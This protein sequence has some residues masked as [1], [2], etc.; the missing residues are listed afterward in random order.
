MILSAPYDATDPFLLHV[1]HEYLLFTT[2]GGYP[3]DPNVPVN[4]GTSIGRW[5]SSNDALPHL[6]PWTSSEVWA[7]DVQKVVGGWALYFTGLVNMSDPPMQCIGSA[8]ASDP[9]GPFVPAS[10]PIV[11][12]SAHRGS[13]D[14]RTFVDG[15]GQLWL[16]WKSDDNADPN[17]PGPDQNGLTGIWSQRLDPTGRQLV[18]QP[19]EIFQPDQPW[20]GT[21]VESPSMVQLGRT[22]YLFFSGNWF[23]QPA[24]AIGVALCASP[25]GPCS[26]V[27]DQPLLA[28]NFEGTGP[29]E[30]SAYVS[31]QGVFLLYTPDHADAPLV[32]PP[33]PVAMARLGFSLAGP[34]L[35][36]W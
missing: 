2:G 24:Y 9:T 18:G 20:E 3:G 26:S 12:Q 11:C 28:S 8:F 33:R 17:T 21:I 4:I 35:A 31:A 27:G 30:P 13:I 6:P 23:N 16:D 25:T 22:Y 1:G 32:T 14:P 19:T 29:G 5:Q 36:T 10:A 34:Y 15:T 7:P